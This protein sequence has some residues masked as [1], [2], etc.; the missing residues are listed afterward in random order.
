LISIWRHGR[1]ILA[2]SMMPWKCRRVVRVK[3]LDTW[4]R[5]LQCLKPKG[6]HPQLIFYTPQ[7]SK[8]VPH[9]GTIAAGEILLLVVTT[10]TFRLVS[11]TPSSLITK[12]VMF[13]D[14]TFIQN[15]NIIKIINYFLCLKYKL[16]SAKAPSGM[17]T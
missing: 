11:A 6:Y 14:F 3:W 5:G 9:S 12:I 16:S 17:E 1:G 15:R 4:A 2:C 7:R 8:V 10:E 13:P